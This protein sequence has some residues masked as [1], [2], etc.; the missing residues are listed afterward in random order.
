MLRMGPF[1][2]SVFT[3]GLRPLTAE[4]RKLK[5]ENL[6]LLV[7]IEKV[8]LKCGSDFNNILWKEI[9]NVL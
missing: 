3:A 1:Q 4:Q 8:P 5:L 2:T 7:T 9:S 6:F